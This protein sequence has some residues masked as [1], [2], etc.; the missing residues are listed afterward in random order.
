MNRRGGN[1]TTSDQKSGF[2]TSVTLSVPTN[3]QLSCVGV[4][5]AATASRSGRSTNQLASAQKK[6]SADASIARTSCGST[7]TTRRSRA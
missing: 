6:N 1:R 7:S 3:S 2:A 4:V 5:P